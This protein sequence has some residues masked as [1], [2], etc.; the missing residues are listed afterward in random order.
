M[1]SVNA[2]A[3]DPVP[4]DGTVARYLLKDV[5]SQGHG[6]CPFLYY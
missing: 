5:Y 3:A 4:L 1:D 2:L 6:W